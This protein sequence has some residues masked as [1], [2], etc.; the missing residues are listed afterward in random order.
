MTLA[1]TM[2]ELA[3]NGSA[4]YRK[5][6]ARH[7]VKGEMF[8]ISFAFLEK[9]RKK[10]KSDHEL[11]TQLWETGNHDARVLATMIADPKQMTDKQAEDWVKELDNY[12]I[13]GMFG[14]LL[15][16]APLAR[17][18]AEKWHKAKAEY[19]SS[20][21]WIVLSHL[22][23]GDQELP[24]EYFAPYLDLIES[25]IHQQQNRVRHEMN[26]ALIA[27]GL[28]SHGLRERALAVAKKIGQVEVDHGETSCKTP[29]AAE[30]IGKTLARRQ[31]KQAKA[32]KA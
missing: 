16:Q 1:E 5:T 20:A 27:I 26:G 23:V 22:A 17:K 13:T 11:A 29:A 14:R 32:K 2:K 25:G 24:D 6:Y 19:V 18:K 31:K 8:G 30:Y 9:L 12:G 15:A 7:G 21:G 3:A 4:Q 28:R 10:I